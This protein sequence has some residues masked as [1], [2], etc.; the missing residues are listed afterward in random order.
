M[1][2]EYLKAVKSKVGVSNTT[3]LFISLLALANSYFTYKGSLLYVDQWP[4]ALIFAFSVQ[5]AIA[6]SLIVLPKVAGLARWAMYLVYS[7]ALVLSVLSAFTFIYT[8]ATGEQVANKYNVK[9]TKAVSEYMS[10]LHQAERKFLRKSLY[11][12]EERKRIADEELNRGRRSGLGPG[13]G[14]HYYLKLEK[15]ESAKVRYGEIKE[16][17]KHFEL[18]RKD[19]GKKLTTKYSTNEIIT[20]LY[21]LRSLASSPEALK[22]KD[23]DVEQAL[24]NKSSSQI[25]KRQ[26]SRK[27]EI[28]N[29]ELDPSECKDLACKIVAICHVTWNRD[30]DEALLEPLYKLLANIKSLALEGNG[31]DIGIAFTAINHDVR[32]NPLVAWLQTDEILIPDERLMTFLVNTNEG[33]N[34]FRVLW[35]L[36]LLQPEV[37]ADYFEKLQGTG[38]LAIT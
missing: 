13:D 17:Y 33:G 28:A 27:H 6:L 25:A 32:V 23:N 22:V 15:Y 8:G 29:H 3:A 26:H 10:D 35:Q 36:S 20:L 14:D 9:L 19:I 37:V 5:A 30:S 7:V 2:K 16:N 38:P 1:W 11:D 4:V 31:N 12:L 21:E 18:L 24:N 34:K